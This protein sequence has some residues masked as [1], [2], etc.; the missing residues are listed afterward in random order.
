MLN[1]LAELGSRFPEVVTVGANTIG[2]ME[3][4]IGARVSDRVA[5]G[6]IS[7]SPDQIEPLSTHIVL[8]SQGLISLSRMGASPA[9]L[10]TIAA[11]SSR[12]SSLL[13]AA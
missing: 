4:I 8:V 7:L 5:A 9:R 12:M 13:G 2:E 10:R 11:T 6:E 3:Q 1:S